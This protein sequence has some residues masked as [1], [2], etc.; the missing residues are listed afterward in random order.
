MTLTTEPYTV[1]FTILI[2][3][4]ESQPFTFQGLY[5]D[6]NIKNRPLIVPTEYSA[7]GRYPNSIGDYSIEG[8]TDRIGVERKSMEDAWGTVLGWETSYQTQR[9]L[10]GRRQR[11]EKELENLQKLEAS[12]VV[13]EASLDDCLRMI[14]EWGVKPA[15]VNAKI[16]L[17]SVIAYMQD[18]RVSWIFC[19][20]RRLAE[21]TTYRFL[22]RFFHKDGE[23]EKEVN[24]H[25]PEKW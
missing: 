20:N 17:R 4:A 6:A 10:P 16:F 11:F 1:P 22:E 5:G 9:D 24:N 13:I 7:L 2:D 12:M 19:D 8:F 14:P 23:K 21:V 18:F 25:G 3:T 15:K